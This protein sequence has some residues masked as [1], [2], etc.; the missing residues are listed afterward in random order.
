M[1]GKDACAPGRLGA[2]FLYRELLPLA[3]VDE[4]E[5]RAFVYESLRDRGGDAP[6]IGDTEDEGGLS[7]Q[8]LGHEVLYCSG[9]G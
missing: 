5:L 2:Q 8:R 1:L 7:G 6:A 9:R 3:L 4:D